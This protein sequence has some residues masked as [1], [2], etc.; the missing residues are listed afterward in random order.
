MRSRSGKA[1]WPSSDRSSRRE[2]IHET[3]LRADAWE[4][5][6]HAPTSEGTVDGRRINP[7]RAGRTEKARRK[8]EV[9]GRGV[10]RARGRA[11]GTRVQDRGRPAGPRPGA[12]LPPGRAGFAR[13]PGGKK[14]RPREGTGAEGKGG[15]RPGAGN[16]GPQTTRGRPKKI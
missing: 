13:R 4:A 15:R 7:R 10:P 9:P 14:W 2:G 5:R 3:R 11:P 6:R 12:D 1:G 16:R 8:P